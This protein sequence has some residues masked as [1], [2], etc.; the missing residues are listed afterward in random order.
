MDAKTFDHRGS[1]VLSTKDCWTLLELG[2][3]RVGRLG[4][5]EDGRVVLRPVNF[6]AYGADLLFRLA[7]GSM[8]DAVI[9][10][11]E[12]AFETDF[13]SQQS[14]PPI[15]WNVTARGP[16]EVVRHPVDLADAV[17]TGLTP[18]T[19]DAGEVYVVMRVA[20]VAG[21]RFVVNALTLQH[22]DAAVGA[23]NTEA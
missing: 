12:V 2:H 15:A 18:L 1:E 4:F 17:S 22:F 19:S 3:D 6:L 13:V 16:I 8:L 14:F 20:S 7:P 21:R 11:A 9:A 10:A 5:H 23:A